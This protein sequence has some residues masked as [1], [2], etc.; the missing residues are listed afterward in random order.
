MAVDQLKAGAA[1]SYLIIVVSILAGVLYTPFMLRMLG[2]AEYGLYSLGASII[3]YLTVLDLGFGNAIVRYTAKFRAEGREEEQYELFGMFIR[4]Y[5][6]IGLV[7]LL[8]GMAFVFN[9]DRLFGATMSSDELSRVAI[10]MAIMSLNLAFTF[11]L[12]IFGSIVTAYEN[13]IFQKVVSLIRI[14]LNP[15]VMIVLLVVGYKAIAL[16]IATTLFNL[17]T[18][19][20]NWWYCRNRLNIKIIYGKFRWEPLKEIFVYSFWIFLNAIM[21]KIY[22]SSGQFIL[23]IYKGAIAVAIYAVAIQLQQLYMMFSTAISGV[24]LP[25]VT[26][27]VAT[28]NSTKAISDLFIKTGRIQYIVMAFI[29]TGFTLFGQPFIAIWAGE[30]YAEAYY[31]TLLLF[32]PLTV[33]LIQ[34]LGI[35]ILQAQNRLKFRSLLYITIALLSLILSITLAPRYGAIGCAAAT[36]LALFVGQIVVMNIYYQRAIKIDIANFW[37]QIAKMSLIPATLLLVGLGILN[38][39]KIE[40]LASLIA[41]GC[42]FAVVYIPLFWRF[43][44]NSYERNLIRSSWLKITNRLFSR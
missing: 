9:V 6:G 40:T 37:L 32:V 34:N 15:L 2:Q 18:L 31:I 12:S 4:L 43:S 14:V 21:D 1:L 11:P 36:S 5:I 23:G 7:A 38:N 19:L 22:W 33:P 35:T 44:M 8:V 28:E 17:V 3:A 13:F 24:F 42:I 10:I 29:L 27:M 16:V 26:A 39:Q 41:A 25:K 30:E 20:A